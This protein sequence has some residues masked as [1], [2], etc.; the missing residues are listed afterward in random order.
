MVVDSITALAPT[1]RVLRLRTSKRAGLG[2]GDGD[3]NERRRRR[4]C[5]KQRN[6]DAGGVYYGERVVLDAATR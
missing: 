2:D 3:E 5:E 4:G 6:S 1:A